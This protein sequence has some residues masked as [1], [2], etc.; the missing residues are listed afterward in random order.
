MTDGGDYQMILTYQPR[1]IAGRR[2]RHL[3]RIFVA[4]AALFLIGSIYAVKLARPA[5]T[6]TKSSKVDRQDILDRQLPEVKFDGTPLK[7][8]IQFLSE[9]S[10]ARFSV[11][12]DNLESI[13]VTRDTPVN[14]RLRNVMLRKAISTVL[15]DAG[16]HGQGQC[17]YDETDDGAIAITSQDYFEKT[18]VVTVI[19][20]VRDVMLARHLATP[21]DRRVLAWAMCTLCMDTGVSDS[22][23]VAAGRTGRMWECGGLL[24][25]VQTR[26]NH[27]QLRH[28]LDRLRSQYATPAAK[29]GGG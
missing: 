7:E 8:A 10:G 15:A 27:R 2:R 6:R 17:H 29:G 26:E 16:S 11:D 5:A 19:Y 14:V 24:I 28:L 4:A 22:W 13:G 1:A 23:V 9:V 25:I 20:D 12:W 3:R 18:N 21:D